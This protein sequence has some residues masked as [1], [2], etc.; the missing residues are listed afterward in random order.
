MFKR[1]LR[2]RKFSDGVAIQTGICSRQ[3]AKPG[4]LNFFA[5]F[6]RD[7]PSFGCGF[8]ALGSVR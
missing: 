1:F 3:D 6:A 4:S 8:A 7:I 5:A 2:M